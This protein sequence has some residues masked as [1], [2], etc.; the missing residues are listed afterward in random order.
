MHYRRAIPPLALACLA[1]PTI[2][3]TYLGPLPDPLGGPVGGI[4]AQPIAPGTADTGP[5]TRSPTMEPIDLRLPSGFNRVYLLQT[6]DPTDNDLFARGDGAVTALFDRSVYDRTGARIPPGT[7]FVIGEVPDWLAHSLGLRRTGTPTTAQP[8]LLDRA[9]APT[10]HRAAATQLTTRLT[11]T[12][13]TT[14]PRPTTATNARPIDTHQPN[15]D[16]DANASAT[17]TTDD[18][19]TNPLTRA[20][21]L[22]TLLQKARTAERERT[23]QEKGPEN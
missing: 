4:D 9:V 12:P 2:A 1:G 17:E 23:A 5:L 15:A 22:H 7:Q 18:P 14:T 21:T 16:T 6:D 10:P 20:T 3:Q 19:Y 8:T 11:H 13:A